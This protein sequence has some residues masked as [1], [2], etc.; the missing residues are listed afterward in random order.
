MTDLANGAARELVDALR[1]RRPQD[2]FR[3]IDAHAHAGPYAL[4]FIP[5]NSAAEMVA[6]MDRCGVRTALFSTNLGIQLDATAGNDSAGRIV[7][8]H[9]ERLRG[10]F[11]VNPWQDPDAE[12]AL[13]QHDPR[14]V[15]IKIHPD[16][17][18]YPLTGPRYAGVWEFAESTGR[19]VLTHTWSGSEYDDLWQ[20][21]EVAERHPL[22]NI[23]AGHAGV[24][25]ET[26]DTAIAIAHRFPRIHLEICGSH[27]HGELIARMVDEVGA[28]QVVYGSDFPFIDMRA[29]L[30]RV[31]F[32]GLGAA[33]A[34]LVLGGNMVK[35]VPGLAGG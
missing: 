5:R 2:T 23:L 15:G 20:L 35:L 1:A 33:E 13:R 3:V 17:H 30:G 28:G 8:E 10:Y 4:F 12:I 34:E 24:L 14:F 19:P 21:A 32:A 7:A 18:H 31:V 27:G 29:A 11:V 26:I 9:P 16:L 22:A 25:R 6:V